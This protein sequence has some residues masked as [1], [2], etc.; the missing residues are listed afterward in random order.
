MDKHNQ[1]NHLLSSTCFLIHVYAESR[2]SHDAA[3]VSSLSS[4][5]RILSTQGKTSVRIHRLLTQIGDSRGTKEGDMLTLSP[6][7]YTAGLY[8]VTKVIPWCV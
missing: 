4:F 8:V 1:V 3:Q 6:E 7:R 2:F 5:S